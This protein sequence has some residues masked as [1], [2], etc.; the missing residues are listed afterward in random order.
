M[1]HYVYLIEKKPAL[2]TEQKYYIGVRSCEC[3]IADDN[4]MGSSKYLTEEVN[5]LGKQSFNKIILKRFDNREDAAKYEIQMHE[6]FDVAK[7]PLFFNKAKQKS[8]GFA[9]GPG[10]LNPF[11]GRKH[12][13][14]YKQRLSALLKT[15][16][17]RSKT[18]NFGLIHTEETK[19]KMSL[20]RK[21]WMSKNKNPRKGIIMTPEEKIKYGANFKNHLRVGCEHCNKIGSIANMAR[22]HNNNCKKKV[23]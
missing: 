23:V 16:D 12:T 8:T 4:Y 6:E 20:K 9:C 19:L 10:E 22:W 5:K 2:E 1:N 13:E 21:E 11:Y 7:S 3:L 18:P 15:K 14:E 17:C